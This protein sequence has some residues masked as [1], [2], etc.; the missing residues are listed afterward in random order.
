MKM[1]L[2][3][4]SSVIKGQKSAL[5]KVYNAVKSGKLINLKKIFVK[6]TYCEKRSTQYDHRDYSKP[7]KVSPV[8]ARCNKMLGKA[9]YCKISKEEF[10]KSFETN[11]N[12]LF[13]KDF[14]DEIITIY[15]IRKYSL[16]K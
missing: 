16:D 12:A 5:N 2:Y 11:I 8:C 4:H 15:E 10:D 3:Y 9:I 1:K 14:E 13:N 6:C 7:L